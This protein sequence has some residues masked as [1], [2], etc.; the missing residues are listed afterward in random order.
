MTKRASTGNIASLLKADNFGDNRPGSKT[1]ALPVSV[2]MMTL[3]LD[4][5]VPYDR[6]PRKTQNA[7]FEEIVDSILDKGGVTSTVSVTKRPGDTHFMV[8]AG[9][10]TRLEAQREA[11]NRSRREELATMNVMFIPYEGEV[12]LMVDHLIENDMRSDNTFIEKALALKSIMDLVREERH[13]D[14]PGDD[15]SQRQWI[16]LLRKEYKYPVSRTVF[17]CYLYALDKLLPAIPKALFAGTG[18]SRVEA[19]NKL[20]S[21]VRKFAIHEGMD[22]TTFDILFQQ[23]LTDCDT[24]V[25][26]VVSDLETALLEQLGDLLGGQDA[27]A[28]RTAI[29]LFEHGVAVESSLPDLD[30]TISD[31]SASTEYQTTLNGFSRDHPEEGYQQPGPHPDEHGHDPNTDPLTDPNTGPYTEPGTGDDAFQTPFQ[32]PFHDPFPPSDDK[33]PA[34]SPSRPGVPDPGKLRHG[35]LKL[36]RSVAGYAQLDQVVQHADFGYGFFIDIPDTELDN[37]NAVTA[38]WLLTALSDI[39]GGEESHSLLPQTSVLKQVLLRSQSEEQFFADIQPLVGNPSFGH[40]GSFFTDPGFPIA[41]YGQL[42]ATL[43][44]LRGFPDSTLWAQGE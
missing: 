31:P 40:I 29:E 37:P 41:D 14:N 24:D 21:R 11:F 23:S 12:T 5:I 3:S 19:I 39:L 20:E 32:S 7:R 25:E 8:S 2:T 43:Q 6:N 33:N 26:F 1:A 44:R 28:L 13:I 36:A 10:N 42:V 38:W 17:W 35:A 4:E 15:L 18:K 30:A 16:A 9:G 22:V 27:P 34:A